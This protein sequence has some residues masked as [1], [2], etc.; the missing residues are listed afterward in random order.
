V[1]IDASGLYK[2]AHWVD[3]NGSGK[4]DP[5]TAK[6]KSGLT[7]FVVEGKE[8]AVAATHRLSALS[9]RDIRQRFEERFTARRMAREYVRVYRS[10]TKQRHTDNN[11]LDGVRTRL[12][13]P[14]PSIAGNFP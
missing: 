10:L 6:F 11:W 3:G 14:A 5:A 4:G 1:P 7:G 12:V 8:E 13:N 2:I 9:R